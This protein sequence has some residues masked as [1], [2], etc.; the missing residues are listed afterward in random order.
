MA[1]ASAS[2]HDGIRKVIERE[3]FRL[4]STYG[5]EAVPVSSSTALA[6]LRAGA[7]RG[8]VVLVTGGTKGLGREFACRAAAEG[9]ARVVLGAR[10][11]DGVREVVREIEAAGGE[12]TGLATD[13]TSWE[14]QVALFDHAVKTY[15]QVDVVVANAGIFE[16]GSFLD[17]TVDTE[18]KLTKPDLGTIDINVVGTLYTARLAF[19]HLR[20]RPESSPGLKALVI[21]GSL[22]SFVAT[23]GCPLYATSKHA[24][25]GLQ[26][27]LHTESAAAGISVIFVAS[28]PVPTDIFGPLRPMIETL[29]HIKLSDTVDAMLFAAAS[30]AGEE[31]LG[32]CTLA[33]DTAGI[34]RIP[35]VQAYRE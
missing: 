5:P 19:H 3:M 13:V 34:F 26:R 20:Q 21:L 10:G 18:G 6:P 22:T 4:R 29:P 30:A 25:L 16:S 31:Q 35:F 9:G 11:E 27:A 15:G 24:L 23:P 7:L 12:A 32:G 8:K 14:S 1:D 33:T 2:E 17:D 28:G